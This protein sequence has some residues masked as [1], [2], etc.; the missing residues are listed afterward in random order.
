LLVSVVEGPVAITQSILSSVSFGR[1][2]GG[3]VP[4]VQVRPGRAAASGHTSR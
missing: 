1:I 2:R 4:G 3:G